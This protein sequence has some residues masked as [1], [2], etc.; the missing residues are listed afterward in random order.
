MEFRTPCSPIPHALLVA[1][2]K[3]DSSK[4]DIKVLYFCLSQPVLAHILALSSSKYLLTLCIMYCSCRF[5][6]TPLPVNAGLWF[7]SASG[8]ICCLRRRLEG[9]TIGSLDVGWTAG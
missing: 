1:F 8:A 5:N 3:S 9:G 2:L 7:G 6:A 4:V